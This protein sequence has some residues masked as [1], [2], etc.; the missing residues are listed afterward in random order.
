MEEFDAEKAARV[1]DR[2]QKREDLSPLEHRKTDL[3]PLVLS[4]QEL[5]GC[6]HSAARQI[7]GKDGERVRALLRQQKGMAACLKGI[8]QMSG[9]R[10]PKFPSVTMPKEPARRLLEK[11][12][13]RERRLLGEL[14]KHVSDPEFGQVFRSLAEGAGQRC[15]TVLEILGRMK[16]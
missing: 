1:W 7:P 9:G 4:A 14:S 2:V 13:H 11:C 12:Y 8:C 15:L 6:Y 5:A 3:T 16:G 10:I